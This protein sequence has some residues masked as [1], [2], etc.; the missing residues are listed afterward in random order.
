MM[1]LLSLVVREV[2]RTDEMYGR[3]EGSC[4]RQRMSSSRKNMLNRNFLFLS[5]VPDCLA[6]V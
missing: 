2:H 5:L 6:T 1:R 3:K 4:V